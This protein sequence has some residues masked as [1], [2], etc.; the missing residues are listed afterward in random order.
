MT[1]HSQ[2][3][4]T[5]TFKNESYHSPHNLCGFGLS[6]NARTRIGSRRRCRSLS[7]N[8]LACIVHAN[9]IISKPRST[10]GENITDTIR[11]FVRH[12][13]FD[14]RDVRFFKD[15]TDIFPSFAYRLFVR[16]LPRCILLPS[17]SGRIGMSMRDAKFLRFYTGSIFVMPL[18][19]D[20]YFLSAPPT[21]SPILYRGRVDECWASW[22]MLYDK[23][24][25]VRHRD[26]QVLNRETLI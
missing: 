25:F 24:S 23:F 20:V 26:M 15:E 22:T 17:R 10:A 14:P 3:D 1:D 13:Q 16:N 18:D 8:W 19:I 9:P 2:T 6:L 11:H 21:M 12:K 7:T 4:P 5:T